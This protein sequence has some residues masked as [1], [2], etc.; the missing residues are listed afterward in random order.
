MTAT[1]S[2]AEVDRNLPLQIHHLIRIHSNPSHLHHEHVLP[3]ELHKQ[4]LR[5]RHPPL[6]GL[7][8]PPPPLRRQRRLPRQ[9]LQMGQP[10]P[11][12][13]GPQIL[14]RKE[15]LSDHLRAL[16][17]RR[18]G[19][20]QQLGELPAVCRGRGA[21]QCGEVAR[22]HVEYVCG[23]VWGGEG[24]LFRRVRDH[25]EAGIYVVQDRVVVCG[26]GV[27]CECALEGGGCVSVR[28]VDD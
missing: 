13:L 23:G 20:L 2:R 28:G 27:E 25:G 6:L 16:R 15:P 10:Q 9:P 12:C 5:L 26:D 14:P 24:G 17:T 1:N 3:H 21:G 7:L 4:L 22:G 18:G 8:H 19:A 11:A